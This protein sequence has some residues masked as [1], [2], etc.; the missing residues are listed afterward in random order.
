MIHYHRER[1]EI[2]LSGTATVSP[3]NPRDTIRVPQPRGRPLGDTV[4]GHNRVPHRVP[5]VSPK[6]CPC[7]GDTIVPKTTPTSG[8][9]IGEHDQRHNQGHD[10]GHNHFVSPIYCIVSLIVSLKLRNTIF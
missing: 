9:T 2:G 5:Y 6:T 8:D 7:W 3:E 10:W 4:E 1:F